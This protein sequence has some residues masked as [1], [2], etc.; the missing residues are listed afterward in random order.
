MIKVG[1]RAGGRKSANS[2]KELYFHSLG[3]LSKP[4]ALALLLCLIHPRS[5]DLTCKLSDMHLSLGA[6]RKAL[7]CKVFHGLVQQCIS[8]LR[9]QGAGLLYMLLDFESLCAV[10]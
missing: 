1:F 8:L 10:S 9:V 2:W 6:P 4:V 5:S 7:A 3:A